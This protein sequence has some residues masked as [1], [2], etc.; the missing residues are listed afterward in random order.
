MPLQVTSLKAVGGYMFGKA[1][2]LLFLSFAGA[3]QTPPPVSKIEIGSGL[4]TQFQGDIAKQVDKRGIDFS[5]DEQ[6]LSALRNSGAQ[7]RLLVSV[8][9]SKVYLRNE[10]VAE[11]E[12]LTRLL[13]CARMEYKEVLLGIDSCESALKALPNNP[14]VLTAVAAMQGRHNCESQQALYNVQKAVRLAPESSEPHRVYGF[15]LACS[16][17]PDRAVQEYQKAIK[18][19]PDNARAHFDLGMHYGSADEKALPEMRQAATLDPTNGYYRLWIGQF[20]ESRGKVDDAFREYKEAEN[21]DPQNPN[22]YIRRAGILAEKKQYDEAIQEAHQAIA[23]GPQFMQSHLALASVLFLKGDFEQA[24]DVLQAA[25][26]AIPNDSNA[27]FRMINLLAERGNLARAISVA[28]EA[29]ARDP[30]LAVIFRYQLA[31]LLEKSGDY[32]GAL[33]EYQR[34]VVTQGENPD[35]LNAIERVNA[36]LYH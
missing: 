33:E 27:Y 19:D 35:L 20:L 1:L 7:D 32:A 10:S 6:F 22:P 3:D 31:D 15:L 16:Q 26:R 12:A 11:N 13:D 30:Q 25:A 29:V 18:L 4:L 36:K 21:V 5:A 23:A 9:H 28:R 8:G 24:V 14:L 34:L 2:A 17:E